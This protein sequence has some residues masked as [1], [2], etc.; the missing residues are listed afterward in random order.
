MN[1]AQPAPLVEAAYA[2]STTE[3]NDAHNE[4]GWL[5]MSVS[6]D[7]NE[8]LGFLDPEST[9]VVEYETTT[10]PGDL[11]DNEQVEIQDLLAVLGAWGPCTNCEADINQS[12]AVDI[13]DLLAIIESWGPCP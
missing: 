6:E 5:V 3:I 12:G 13:T 11:N 4:T 9:L 7:W 8:Q 1:F 10:C 2:L